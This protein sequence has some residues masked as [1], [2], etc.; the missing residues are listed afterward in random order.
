MY[1]MGYAVKNG[2]LGGDCSPKPYAVSRN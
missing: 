1:C 2:L